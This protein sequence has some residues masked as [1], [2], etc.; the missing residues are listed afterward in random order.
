MN[1][2]IT[3]DTPPANRQETANMANGVHYH[4]EQIKHTKQ[5][6]TMLR[7]LLTLLHDLV[8]ILAGIVLVFVFF[9]RV[10][11]V[12]GDSMLP[13]LQNNDRL[14][15]LSNLW[16]SSPE[17]GDVVVARI[18]EFS[19]E[20]IVKRVIAVEGDVIDI[21]FV[22]GIV[23]VNGEQLQENYIRELTLRH[24][25]SEGVSFPLEIQ[26]GHVFL[27]G[28]NRNDSY[29]SRYEP[30]GQVDCRY[31]L[32]KVIFLAI[33]GADQETRAVDFGR[34]GALE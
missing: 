27:M 6:G 23:S 29:D 15:L 9:V 3:R 31:I 33:P 20:P 25:G 32:G 11:T 24:F 22:S 2:T 26:Q 7:D 1:H 10:I 34:I 19:S 14:V 16:Y 12:D 18:P 21:D 17:R 4:P 28:D 8:Y 13:T 5:K 30:I